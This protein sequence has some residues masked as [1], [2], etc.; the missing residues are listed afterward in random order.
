M[1][2]HALELN[3]YNIKTYKNKGTSFRFI[4]KEML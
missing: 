2:D 1:Y 3:P 4:I